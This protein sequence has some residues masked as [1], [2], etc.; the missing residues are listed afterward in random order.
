MV[1]V[2]GWWLMLQISGQCG[3]LLVNMLAGYWLMCY[4]NS[5]CC[6]LVVDEVS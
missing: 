3:R 4:V 2:A 1:N 5:Q 6:G